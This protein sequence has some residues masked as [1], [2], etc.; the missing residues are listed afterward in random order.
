M[1]INPKFTKR[2]LLTFILLLLLFP[3]IQFRN[4]IFKVKPL[5]G[6][7]TLAADTSITA[8]GWFTAEYQQQKELFTND[9]FGFRSLLVRLNNQI[10][11]WL[12]NKAKANGVIIGKNNYLYEENYIKACLGI[13]YVGEDSIAHRMNRLKYISDTLTKLNKN[14]ILVY[15]AGKGGFYP[16]FI[17]DEYGKKRGTT[18]FE[19]HIK[20]SK[21]LK[22]NFIDFNSYFIANK[23]KSKYLLYPQYGI[24][25]S[26]YGVYLV[27]DSIIRYIEKLRNIDM[28]NAFYDKVDFEYP[29]NTDR[30]IS[31]GMNL[32]FNF[33]SPMMA[34]PLV[35]YQNDSAKT[36]PSVLVISDSFYWGIFSSGISAAFDKTQFWYYNKEVIQDGSNKPLAPFELNLREEIKKYDVVI[37]LSTDA[38]LPAMGWGFIENLYDMFQGK[39]SEV[40]FSVRL[41]QQSKVMRADANWMNLIREKAAKNNITP[42]SM[43]T[44]DAIWVLKENDKK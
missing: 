5:F 22:L 3:L 9:N 39:T 13:D 8:K 15:A 28:P 35:K 17:P 33:K 27:E 4:N 6:A 7:V 31:D 23:N 38:N 25:W 41:A 2:I 44:L 10:A 29:K 40:D 32:L 1:S 43:L 19:T 16:E 18:N 12:Y 42:D 20:F 36:R 14:L 37:I 34:Y 26:H 11:Y 24:H 21:Q 30:D